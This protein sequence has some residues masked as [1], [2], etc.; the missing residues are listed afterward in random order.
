ME[1][2]GKPIAKMGCCGVYALTRLSGAEFADVFN[3]F[4]LRFGRSSRWTGGTTI[5]QRL[6]VAKEL[7]LNLKKIEC[8][9]MKLLN[10]VKQLDPNKVYKITVTR[11]VLTFE[12]GRL[13]DQRYQTGVAPE[14]CLTARRFVKSIYEVIE[15]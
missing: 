5:R 1:F 8:D 2:E 4:R 3:I 6:E 7:G 13:F 11:H 14:N 15:G 12:N 10:A 9:R